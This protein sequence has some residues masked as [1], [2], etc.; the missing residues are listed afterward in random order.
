MKNFRYIYLLYL[1]LFCTINTEAQ[2]LGSINI[3]PNAMPLSNGVKDSI[4][5]A[6]MEKTV[7]PG[8]IVVRHGFQIKDNKT[9]DLYGLNGSQIFGES[10]SLAIKASDGIFIREDA[11]APWNHNNS[12]AKYKGKYTPVSYKTSYVELN[13]SCD[14]LD[15]LLESDKLKVTN[16][17]DIYKYNTDSFNNNCLQLDTISESKQGWIMWLIQKSNSKVF[18][19]DN[20]SFSCQ[21]YKLNFGKLN[22]VENVTCPSDAIVIGGVYVIPFSIGIGKIELKIAGIL[23]K[24]NDEWKVVLPFLR[25]E[26]TNVQTNEDNENREILTP[27]SDTTKK[28]KSRK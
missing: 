6:I 21:E 1:L 28:K 4:M 10:Y 3:K 15:F 5:C 9:G 2:L 17:S 13:D 8:L 20:L 24:I 26:R 18:D 22:K 7:K 14:F 25:S 12:F 19:K 11:V 16:D 23:S 27:A